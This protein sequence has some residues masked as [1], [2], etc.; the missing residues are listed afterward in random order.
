MSE[1]SVIVLKWMKQRKHKANSSAAEIQVLV[2]EVEKE[3]GDAAC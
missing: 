1:F 3:K 2:Y